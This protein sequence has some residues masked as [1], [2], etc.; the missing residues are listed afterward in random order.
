MGIGC[1]EKKCHEIILVMF[2]LVSIMING[3]ALNAITQLKDNLYG[4][5]ALTAA[6]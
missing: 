4:D 6:Q 2:A 5:I 1:T 3:G